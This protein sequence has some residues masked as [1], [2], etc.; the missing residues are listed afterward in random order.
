MSG[1]R[2]H[3]DESQAG[4][5]RV[6]GWPWA[7]GAVLVLAAAVAAGFYWEQTLTVEQVR[8]SGNWFV[9][10]ETL[11]KQ[12][13]VPTGVRPDSLDYAGII[14]R[15]ERIPYVK[16]AEVEVE[17]SGNLLVQIRERQPLAVLA[18]NNPRRYV[19]AE[20][21]VL[22]LVLGKAVDLPLLYGFTAA[23]AGDTLKGEDFAAA[24]RFLQSLRGRT[25][26][27]ATISEVAWTS[28][29]GIVALTH[30]NGVKL[31]FGREAYE[32]RLQNWE[33]FYAKIVRREGIRNMREID[34]RFRGQI[35]TR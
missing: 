25:V 23:E 30:E 1:N 4:Q 3:N 10:T 34:L 8:F 35:I 13:S 32:N 2:P 7:A 15:A 14:A 9:D 28:G 5:N 16:R 24:S 18:G 12:V 26:S 19:D 21:V 31:L 27:D 33:A 6:A 29:E 17:P 22:P 11:A 20:G